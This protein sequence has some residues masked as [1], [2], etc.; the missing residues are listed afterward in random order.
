M[1]QQTYNVIDSGQNIVLDPYR[2][3][4]KYVMRKLDRKQGILKKL[5]YQAVFRI[6]LWDMDSWWRYLRLQEH[7]IFPPSFYFTHT[8]EEIKKITREE[9]KFIRDTIDQMK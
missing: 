1:E 7:E 6:I 5:F 2:S 4:L 9:I 3:I 8:Q